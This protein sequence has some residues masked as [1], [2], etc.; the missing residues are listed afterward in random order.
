MVFVLSND[1]QP[2]DPCHPARARRLLK[3][4]KAAVF[5]RFPFTIILKH[6]STAQSQTHAHRLKLDPGSKATGIAVVR[7]DNGRVVWAGE[8]LHRGQAIRDALARRQAVRRSRRQRKARY[9]KPR[10]LNRRRPAGWLPPS[11]QHRV[12]TTLTW[13][14]RLLRL[15][16]IAALST[17][18]VRFDTQLMQDAEISGVMYQ[19]G[20][21]A[22]YEVREYVLEKWH[23]RCAYCDTTGVPL[24]LEHIVPHS[25]SGSDRVSNLSLACEPCNLRKGTQ[26]AAEFGFPQ[27]QAQAHQPLKDAAAVNATRWALYRA[28][29]AL[30]LPVEVG[31]GG[32]TKY[33]RT[34]L[35]L[36]KAHWTDAACVGA[37]TPDVLDVRNV[38]SLL[39]QATGHGSRQ[40]CRMSAYGFPRTG[41]KQANVVQG[42]RTGD[43]V[44]A[45]VP[46]GKKTGAYTGRVA[47][48]TSGSFD[49]VTAS[50]LV[51]GVWYR[52]CRLLHRA[53]GYRYT[54]SLR[55]CARKQAEAERSSQAEETQEVTSL[56]GFRA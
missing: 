1:R 16:P 13:T 25:R 54:N 55:K 52:R 22:G 50:G 26:T 51:Q 48:R 21:L 4:G 20:T 17:E 43:I 53:D 40:M 38:H 27:I 19:Q 18:L 5:R 3:A 12:D 6:R 44:R 8:L 47:V 56:L 24:Q 7:E 14:R 30:G 31:T 28:L 45:V 46:R 33:N 9:R 2:L 11:L 36:P 10:F 32:R 42:F 35:G 37:S 39:I 34:R 29:R 49:I 41:P 23:R 15:V